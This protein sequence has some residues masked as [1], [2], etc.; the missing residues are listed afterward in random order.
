MWYVSRNYAA[1]LQQDKVFTA[2][3]NTY[4]RH[5]I[6]SYQ[7]IFYTP[8]WYMNQ[9]AAKPLI[10]PKTYLRYFRWVRYTDKQLHVDSIQR[11]RLDTLDFF[12]LTTWILRFGGWVVINLYWFRPY[13]KKNNVIALRKGR[14]VYTNFC[15]P[16]HEPNTQYNNLKRFKLLFTRS[17][18]QSLQLNSYYCF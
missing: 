3:L 1:H 13:R 16:T 12:H 11:Y 6:Y 17:F 9:V 8:Y 5:G 4:L 18:Y 10:G 14:K 15:P 7:D 2:L